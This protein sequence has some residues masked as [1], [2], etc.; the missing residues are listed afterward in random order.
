MKLSRT[1][2]AGLPAPVVTLDRLAAA[3]AQGTGSPAA[4][5]PASVGF[6]GRASPDQDHRQPSAAQAELGRV[7][8][9][10]SPVVLSLAR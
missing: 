8:E 2:N 1:I 6:A 7:V 4:P 5:V 10:G 3:Q 9:F